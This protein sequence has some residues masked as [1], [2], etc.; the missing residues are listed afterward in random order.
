MK[1]IIVTQKV[2]KE[3]ENLGAFYYW[4]VMLS[5]RVEKLVIIADSVG[6]TEFPANVEICELGK[7]KGYGSLHRLF[8]LWEFFWKHYGNS[9]AIFF[10]QIPEY[11]IAA[12]PF[13]FLRK[14]TT[15]LWY[16]H[17]S[18]TNRLKLAEKLVDYVFTSSEAGFRLPSKKVFYVGQAIN[19]A[20]FKP[21]AVNMFGERMLRL[22]TIGRIAPVKNYEI[23]INACAI[24]KDTWKEPWRLSVVGGP[25]FPRDHEYF[26][27][28]KKLVH[29]KGLTHVVEFLGSKP[30]SAVPEILREHDF[31]LN[32]SATG[33]LDKAVFEAM[34][35]GLTVLTANE[36][37]RS[38]LPP[39]YFLEHTSPDFLAG[40]IKALAGDARPNAELRSIVLERHSLEKTVDRI[41]QIL[42]EEKYALRKRM[43]SG[44]T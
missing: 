29:D 35:C 34:A 16:A 41:F 6:E 4:F 38:I 8:R 15:A 28:L 24:L 11:A 39:R 22:V 7:K 20:L 13:L 1:L 23:I 40:R 21:G 32:V 44:S 27:A 25:I 10:H 30:Y 36:A 42:T 17:K 37:Y 31:F 43:P 12:A 3:D 26:S 2:D 33:S 9:D 19:T 14:K 18:V 5:S